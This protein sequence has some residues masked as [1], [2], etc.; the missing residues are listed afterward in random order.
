MYTYVS[1]QPYT[2][3]LT[4]CA[5]LTN[6][7]TGNC[8]IKKIYLFTGRTLLSKACE[9]NFIDNPGIIP[10]AASLGGIEDKCLEPVFQSDVR[11]QVLC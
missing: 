3:I 11:K 10:G 7:R 1:T 4:W 9:K 2:C 8:M 6:N 5:V